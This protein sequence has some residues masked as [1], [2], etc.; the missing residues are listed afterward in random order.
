MTPN[1]M[2]CFQVQMARNKRKE[3]KLM[4]EFPGK[5]HHPSF[6]FSSH[7]PFHLCYVHFSA[8]WNFRR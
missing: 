3:S 7:V 6:S 4:F 2:M 1:Q 8:I 5:V